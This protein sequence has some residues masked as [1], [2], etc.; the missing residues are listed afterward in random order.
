MMYF[1]VS[2]MKD[3]MRNREDKNG[4]C[5]TYVL[6]DMWKTNAKYFCLVR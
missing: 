1:S 5:D 3:F 6:A 4:D 2:V